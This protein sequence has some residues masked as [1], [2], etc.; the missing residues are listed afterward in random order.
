VSTQPAESRPARVVFLDRDGTINIDHGY[1]F[2]VEQFEFVPGAAEAMRRLREAGFHLA[3]VSNQSG[4]GRGYYTADDVERLHQHM[5]VELEA[6][7]VDVSAVAYCPHDPEE[8]CVCRKPRGGMADLVESQLQLPIDYRASWMIGDKPADVGFGHAIGARTVLLQSR[9][10]TREEV[11]V[12]PT[13]FAP[14][15]EAAVEFVIKESS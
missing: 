13:G 9:Y 2:R 12:S 15:L 10:W 6:Q 3:V 7:G 11:D 5:R 4:I 8:D 14:S 1:V